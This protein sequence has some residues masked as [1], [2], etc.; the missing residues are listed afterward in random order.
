[1]YY[2]Y[3]KSS[4]YYDA[5]YSYLE[6]ARLLRI[7]Q[8]D[9]VLDVGC[10]LNHLKRVY[11][12]LIGVDIAR[13]SKADILVD[14][15]M[16][17]FRD[18]SF[19]VAISVSVI[20]H[21]NNPELMLREMCR[22][23]RKVGIV[24]VNK[25]TGKHDHRHLKEY[26]IFELLGLMRKYTDILGWGFGGIGRKYRFRNKFLKMIVNWLIPQWIVSEWIAAAGKVRG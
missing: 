1:M 21:I 14:C 6:L 9:L 12:N 4:N 24:T 19:D 16:L 18:K 20:E 25:F 2:D 22:V 8:N 11:R 15:R 5:L 13:N 23:A 10:G 7:T 26:S 17:P 3:S